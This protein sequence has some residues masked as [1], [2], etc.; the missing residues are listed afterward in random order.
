MYHEIRYQTKTNKKYVIR[1]IRGGLH[2]NAS[3]RRYVVEFTC[4]LGVSGILWM[5]QIIGFAAPGKLP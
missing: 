1:T 3:N 5:G 4:M 2:G